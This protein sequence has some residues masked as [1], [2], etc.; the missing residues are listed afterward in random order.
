MNTKRR[1]HP[2]LRQQ[3]SQLAETYGRPA[4][5]L[6]EIRRPSHS[7]GPAGFPLSS[8]R[9]SEVVLVVPCPNDSVIVHTK[10]FY[11][12]G[13]WRLPTG[14]IRRRETIEKALRRE[15]VEE[16]G[17]SLE[18]IRFLFH[19]RFRWDGFDKQ[20]HSFGFLLSEP[21]GK[22]ESLDRREQISAFKE[23]DR[24]SLKGIAKRLEALRGNWTGWGRFRAAPHR[25]L[26]RL[27]P[28]DGLTQPREKTP[29]P[30]EP[31]S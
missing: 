15:V 31:S 20:F 28:E 2:T 12:S 21:K 29:P 14:G 8:R 18:P 13:I 27:W 11:P 7:S 22:I 16:T 25:I 4:E 6:V 1:R 26:L 30:T 10:E 24:A 17:Q 23:A 3:I 19:L 9:T 5:E